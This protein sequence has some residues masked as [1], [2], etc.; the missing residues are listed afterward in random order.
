M[1]SA[2]A[3]HRFEQE[4][5]NAAKNRGWVSYVVY[6]QLKYDVI[7]RGY[8][9]QCKRLEWAERSGKLNITKTVKYRQNDFDVLALQYQSETYLI[10]TWRLESKVK[11][12]WLRSS[13]NPFD[14]RKW[15]DAWDVF[16]GKKECNVPERQTLLFDC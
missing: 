7:V 11:P 12:G 15:I 6:K 3:W 10:P 4:I 2:P 13:I 1:I 5:V 8:T 14:Y 9:V 16:D